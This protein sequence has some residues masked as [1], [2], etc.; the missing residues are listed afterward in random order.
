MFWFFILFC[1]NITSVDNRIVPHE[2]IFPIIEDIEI[3]IAQSKMQNAYQDQQ[4][5][6]L[7]SEW[8]LQS[9]NNVEEIEKR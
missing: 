7:F 3:K 6:H 8:I 9:Y 1:D 4:F 2:S 5:S